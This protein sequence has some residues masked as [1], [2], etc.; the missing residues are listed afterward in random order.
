MELKVRLL[1]NIDPW[2]WASIQKSQGKITAEV[3]DCPDCA[4]CVELYTPTT[5]DSSH[6]TSIR[7]KQELEIKTWIDTYWKE[8]K[9]Q[10]QPTKEKKKGYRWPLNL[11]FEL[12]TESESTD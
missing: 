8:H 1:C 4:H 9:N 6:L 12:E 7:N 2:I 11:L 5:T 3:A 10:T